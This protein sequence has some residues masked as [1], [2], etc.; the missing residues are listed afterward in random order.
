[1]ISQNFI[2]PYTIHFL[3]SA[4]HLC[5]D[6]RETVHFSAKARKIKALQRECSTPSMETQSL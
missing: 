4:R 2:F 5:D 6:S 3:C 1:M